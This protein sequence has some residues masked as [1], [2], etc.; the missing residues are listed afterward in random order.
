MPLI[1]RTEIWDDARQLRAMM[2]YPIK[3]MNIHPERVRFQVDTGP[4]PF[5]DFTCTAEH[6]IEWFS[7]AFVC[8]NTFDLA[9]F[10]LRVPTPI[11]EGDQE[12][13]AVLDYSDIRRMKAKN[14][15]IAAGM[16]ET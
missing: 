16:D 10:I 12:I 9:E 8:Y 4:L 14:T 3:T 1:G 6:Q 5:P 11:R 15:V 2:E 7:V 13:C